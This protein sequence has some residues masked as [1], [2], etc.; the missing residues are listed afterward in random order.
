M[1]A[2][3]SATWLQKGYFD[4]SGQDQH[5][6][7]SLLVKANLCTALGLPKN[8]LS[9]ASYPVGPQFRHIYWWRE[10]SADYAE[11]QFMAAIS[12]EHP[13][14]SLG[15]SVEKGREDR[16]VG[17][18]TDA[19]DRSTWDWPRLVKELADILSI[20]VPAL[21]KTSQGPVHLRVWSR[22]HSEADQAGW[23]TRASSFVSEQWF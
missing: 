8:G 11:A 4:F 23:H 12:R 5:N 7:T 9:V 1:S 22:R 6:T 17:T 15:V 3:I 16:A 13:V 19:M 10:G 20:D 14:L 21:E 2:S 18:G